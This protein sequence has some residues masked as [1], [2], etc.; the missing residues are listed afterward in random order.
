MAKCS[1]RH[2]DNQATCAG[3]CKTCYAYLY[4]WSKRGVAAALR[5]RARLVLWQERLESAAPANVVHLRRKRA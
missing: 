1:F 5:R 3:I 2:C 4:Y